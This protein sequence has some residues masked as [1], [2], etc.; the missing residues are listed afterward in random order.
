ML[1]RHLSRVQFI[2]SCLQFGLFGKVVLFQR[3]CLSLDGLQLLPQPLL[4]LLVLRQFSF[5][6]TPPFANL[7]GLLLGALPALALFSQR[8]R[9]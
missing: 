5:Q 3:L 7:A 6:F 4:R 1:H 8:C 2:R 9:Q